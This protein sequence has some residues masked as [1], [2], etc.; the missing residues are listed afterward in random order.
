MGLQVLTEDRE[1][2]CCF[3][4]NK[5]S[6]MERWENR[7]S[8]SPRNDV[9]RN[10]IYGLSSRC[11]CWTK[12]RLKVSS[13]GMG[14]TLCQVSTVSGF[15]PAH[16]GLVPWVWKIRFY[17]HGLATLVTALRHR[18]LSESASEQKNTTTPTTITTSL[19][20]LIKWVM[21]CQSF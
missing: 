21:V 9:K 18:P 15:Y 19:N 6:V 3:P 12:N 17:S 5:F 8:N 14:R 13:G 20:L 1:Y 10:A 4:T 16:P 2:F 7:T 11:C